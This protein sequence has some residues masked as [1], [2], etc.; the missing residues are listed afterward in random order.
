[1]PTNMEMPLGV[2]IEKLET[3]VRLASDRPDDLVAFGELWIYEEG[4]N[5]PFCKVKGFTIRIKTF[6]RADKPK[7]TVVFPAYPTGKGFLTS[8]YLPNKSLWEDVT[9]LFLEEYTQVSGGL[10]AEEAEG[11]DERLEI[12][13]D[14]LDKKP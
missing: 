2:T 9:N 1:M 3:K 10:S 14:E 5:E 4:S 8:F 11:L 6:G 13:P 7:L 12:V